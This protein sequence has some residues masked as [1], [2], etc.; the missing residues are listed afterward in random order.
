MTT[1]PPLFSKREKYSLALCSMAF[2][3]F[4]VMVHMMAGSMGYG[5]LPKFKVEATPPPQIVIFIPRA[6]HTPRPTP[7]PQP[8]PI[9]TPP[10]VTPPRLPVV[11]PPKNSARPESTAGPSEQRYSPPP[12]PG[13]VTP[14]APPV[15]PSAE[16]I[17][18]AAPSGPSSE[19]PGTFRYKAPLDYPQIAI[20]QNIEGTVVVL[21][22]IGPDGALLSASIAVSSGN[23][24]LDEAAL[25]AARA[26]RYTPY[27]VNGEPAEQQYK[28]VYEFKLNS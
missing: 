15:I 10:K 26:S 17:A 12:T 20:D 13:V 11:H 22:T 14:S 25:K 23:A 16:P 2:V 8:T 1:P 18:S 7:T 5:L 24:S 21:V 3:A 6:K 19:Q 28:I 27:L 4:S 9:P